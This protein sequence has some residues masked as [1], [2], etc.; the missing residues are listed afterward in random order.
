MTINETAYPRH[1]GN[2]V[3]SNWDVPPL[4]PVPVSRHERADWR[5]GSVSSLSPA[6]LVRPSSGQVLWPPS[7]PPLPSGQV[8]QPPSVLPLPSGQVLQQPSVP[9]VP[10]VRPAPA[11]PSDPGPAAPR[12]VH[13]SQPPQSSAVGTQGPTKSDLRLEAWRDFTGTRPVVRVPVEPNRSVSL[14]RW[15]PSWL[16]VHRIRVLLWVQM[17]TLVLYIVQ[18]LIWPN[19]API[20]TTFER[21]FQWGAILWVSSL[22][23]GLAGLVGMLWYRHSER[24]DY[25]PQIDNLVVFRIVSRGTNEE[26]LMST[27]ERCRSEMRENPFFPYLIEVVTDGD[28]FEAPPYPDVEQVKVPQSYQ[29]PNGSLYKA[30]ALQYALEYSTVPDDAWLVHL[31][32]ETQP[33]SSGI[34][35]IA[36]TVAEEEASGQLRIGQGAILYHRDW[37]THP[38]LTLADN[39]RT[40]DDFARFHLQ[41]KIGVT[42][43][44]LHGSYI[45]C[46]ND[47]EKE[48]GFDFGPVGSITEDAF[49][50]LKC[51]EAGRRARWVEGYLEEQST[52]SV[53]DFMKQRRRW[54]LGLLKV[55]L[56]APVGLRYRISLGLNTLLW[57]MAPLGMIYTILNLFLGGQANPTLRFMANIAV[58]CFA[59]LYMV[60][61]SANLDEHGI[62]SKLQRMKWYAIQLVMLPAFSFMESASILYAIFR[63]SMGF[64]VVKK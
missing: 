5:D 21:I 29:T 8:L 45:V 33:T 43:F 63:P 18:S 44:G 11:R 2:E 3:S 41:H 64:H 15:L 54:Y 23:P 40:G 13:R 58:A 35:G 28:V 60:G 50:A 12:P 34:K 27:I 10:T 22:I 55:S 53:P 32:E 20:E 25:C 61:L 17:V 36:W 6:A 30:R 1:Q 47:V 14:S 52:Q 19:A 16:T 42:L 26:A 31:D 37:R 57:T 59:T 49:W 9:P 38:L 39:V 51:M 46:R 56:F 62:T 7:V 24:L 48:V 4:Q